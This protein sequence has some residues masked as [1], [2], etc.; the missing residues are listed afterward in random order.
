MHTHA[1]TRP[2]VGTSQ[3]L[4][5]KS[6][7]QGSQYKGNAACPF[8]PSSSLSVPDYGREPGGCGNNVIDNPGPNC[9]ITF[10]S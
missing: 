1:H 2:E 4:T 10:S 7:E 3:L 9:M 5:Y 8:N 6:K